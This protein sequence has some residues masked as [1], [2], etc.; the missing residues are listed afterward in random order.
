MSKIEERMWADLIRE[1]GADQALAVR[2]PPTV[3]RRAPRAPLA[4]GGLILLGAI[5]AAALALTAGTSTTPA[6]AV[7]VNTNGSVSV[8]L[9]EVLGV[10]GANE[11]LA[12]LGVRA[13]IAQIEAGCAQ[14]GE[15]AFPPGHE[16]HELQER[17]VETQDVGEGFAGLA[18]VIHPDAIP[19]GDTLLI[20]AQ[21]ANGGRP[22]TMHDGKLVSVLASTVGLYRGAAPTC[23]PPGT[24]Y[25]G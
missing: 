17:M 20:T 11:A 7:T 10:S 5:L 1:P 4:V 19:Q 21:L 8:T 22:V 14:I 16:V 13:R 18:W 25:P 3:R 6:Y 24:V 12:R 9:N 15:Q 2:Q 23:Q